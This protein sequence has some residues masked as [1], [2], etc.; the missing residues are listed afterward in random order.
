MRLARGVKGTQGVEV[1]RKTLFSLNT[2][3][4]V[5]Q[6]TDGTEK[7]TTTVRLPTQAYAWVVE[8]V[9]GHTRAFHG[10]SCVHTD[11][12]VVPIP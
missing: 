12:V 1:H 4:N 9:N 3:G 7:E 2:V 6:P 5:P 10:L 8:P 11:I